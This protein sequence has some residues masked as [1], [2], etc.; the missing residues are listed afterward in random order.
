MQTRN[1]QTASKGLLLHLVA[2]GPWHQ[3]WANM[4]QDFNSNARQGSSMIRSSLQVRIT[5]AGNRA[6]W[7]ICRFADPQPR[8]RIFHAR[9]SRQSQVLTCSQ[10]AALA[11]TLVSTAASHADT[12][13]YRVDAQAAGQCNNQALPQIMIPC[14]SSSKANFK[15]FTGSGALH[16]PKTLGATCYNRALQGSSF[17]GWPKKRGP[18]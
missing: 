8:I 18:A 3:T 14:I 7:Q 17:W 5:V 2:E 15:S 10:P 4:C 13:T 16:G 1:L 12:K 9:E 6:L 11:R